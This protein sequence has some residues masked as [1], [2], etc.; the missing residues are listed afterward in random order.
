MSGCS[1]VVEH[2]TTDP[3]S[4]GSNPAAAQRQMKI[5]EKEHLPFDL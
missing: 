4:K 3:E 1:T 2:S 5:E